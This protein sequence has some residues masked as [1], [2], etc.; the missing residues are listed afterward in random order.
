M[1]SEKKEKP[2]G[3]SDKL[4]EVVDE[5]DGINYTRGNGNKPSALP[6]YPGVTKE[7]KANNSSRSFCMGVPDRII[8]F[9]ALQFLG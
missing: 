8:L 6:R 2:G 3:K 9:F 4:Y 7:T 5:D 1:R